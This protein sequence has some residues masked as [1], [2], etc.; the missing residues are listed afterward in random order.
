MDDEGYLQTR[1]GDGGGQTRT[2]VEGIFGAGDVVDYHYQQ[3]VTAAGMGC[4]A[5]I[6]AD[7]Y[8][9][10]LERAGEL[11]VADAEVEPAAGDD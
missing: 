6:D 7:G 9:E 4:K 3:A 11:G 1:G 2:A 5:A 10:D 8:L